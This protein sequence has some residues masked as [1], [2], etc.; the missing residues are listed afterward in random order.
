MSNDTVKHFVRS[1]FWIESRLPRPFKQRQTTQRKAI[2]FLFRDKTHFR[3]FHLEIVLAKSTDIIQI[4]FI[5]LL[6]PPLLS[7]SSSHQQKKLSPFYLSHLRLFPQDVSL[8]VT[9]NPINRAGVS[10]TFC[11]VTIVA[12]PATF[13]PTTYYILYLHLT[14]SYCEVAIL[15]QP[16]LC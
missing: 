16:G 13:T 2:S 12:Y 9:P 4:T 14:G 8:V 11:Y 5:Q 7:V 1:L 10:Y 15:N 6:C 3:C